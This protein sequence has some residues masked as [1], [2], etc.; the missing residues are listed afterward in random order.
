[1]RLLACIGMLAL[2]TGCIRVAGS[3][4]QPTALERQLLGEYERLDEELV[5]ASSVRGGGDAAQSFESLK[6]HAIEQ[7]SMQRFNEDDIAELKAQKCLAETLDAHLVG[8][9]C[10]FTKG[11]EKAT[12]RIERI[13]REENKARGAILGRLRARE[14]RRPSRAEQ[15]R[16]R[17][18]A[19]HLRPPAPRSRAP[20]APRRGR[21]R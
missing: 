5:W 18:A 1:M 2:A 19:P 7:R 10:A 11:D 14:E 8:R 13:L 20:R 12:A 6:A 21:A 17:R 3:V 9:P 4:A 15:I 16:P